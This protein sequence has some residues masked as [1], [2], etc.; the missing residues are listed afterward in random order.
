MLAPF[1][2]T[3]RAVEAVWGGHRLRELLRRDLPADVQI[4]ETWEV[5]DQNTVETGPSAGQTLAA[6][7]AADPVGLLGA[8]GVAALTGGRA[9]PLLVK[10]IDARGMLSVQVHPSDADRPGEGKTEAYYVLEARPGARLSYGLTPETD[11]AALGRAVAEGT[12]ADCLS[13][14]DVQAGDAVYTPAGTVHAVGAGLVFFEV[15]QSSTVTYRL[16]DWGRLG[17]DGR[18]RQ[19]HVAESLAVTRFP[20]PPAR[21]CSPLAAP[22]ADGERVVLAA[23]PHFAL[24]RLDGPG[25]SLLGGQTFHLL[26]ALGGDGAVEGAWPGVM[27]I[28]HGR[29][30][31]VPAA[32]G[33][34]R[35]RPSAG[36]LLLRCF[37]PDLPADVLAPLRAAGHP[38]DAIATLGEAL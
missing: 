36:G 5:Y 4:G 10:F 13:R 27:S 16:Y 30:I 32:A 17:M 26:T 31:V 11:R 3:P 28:P 24:E 18:P 33:E 21:R 38:D 7:I 2:V 6:A 34:Y 37:I 8:R 23:G 1:L 29:T 9:F 35:Y 12:V 25:G 15:Q 19:L 22:D 20:Q 14:I